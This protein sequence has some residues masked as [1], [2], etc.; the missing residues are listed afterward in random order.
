MK[1]NDEISLGIAKIAE[2]FGLSLVVLFGSVATGSDRPDSD[3]D[4]GVHFKDGDPGL[5]RTLDL[6]AELSN[7]FQG[8]DIDLSILNRADPLFLK[9]ISERC[10]FLYEEPGKGSAFL[11]LAFKRYQDHQKYLDMERDFSAA[12]VKRIAS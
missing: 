1:F 4:I 10:D 9:K 2:R 7:L 5:S 6:H 12:Y 8:R 3:V 11:L